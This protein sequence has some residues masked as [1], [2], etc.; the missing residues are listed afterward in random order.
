MELA[1]GHT[2]RILSYLSNQS[3]KSIVNKIHQNANVEAALN[4][5][6]EKPFGCSY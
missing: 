3:S 6:K 2:E 4:N 5:R 1:E